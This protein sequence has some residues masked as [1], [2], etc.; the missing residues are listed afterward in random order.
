[1]KKTI[2]LLLSIILVVALSLPAM[3]SNLEAQSI[4]SHLHHLNQSIKSN[5]INDISTIEH[6]LQSVER[7][8][9]GVNGSSLV[10][11]GVDA[12]RDTLNGLNGGNSGGNSGGSGYTVKLMGNGEAVN[13]LKSFSDVSKDGEYYWA[14]DAIYAMK[15]EGL[16][17]GTADPDD[18]GAAPFSPKQTMTRAQFITV[19]VRHLFKGE[20]GTATTNDWWSANMDLA[21]TK[22]LVNKSDFNGDYDHPCSREEMAYLLISAA[23]IK[24]ESYNQASASKIPDYNNISGK[25]QTVALQAVA[26][27]L[28]NGKEGN[29]FDPQGTMSRAEAATVIYRLINPNAR[30]DTSWAM[31]DGTGNGVGQAGQVNEWGNVILDT[32]ASPVG[33]LTTDN[34][35]LSI[36]EGQTLGMFNWSI[37]QDFSRNNVKF[38]EGEKHPVPIQGDIVVKADG[39]E[40]K[41]DFFYGNDGKLICL[42]A[43]GCDIWTGA[44][45]LSGGE[46]FTIGVNAFTG[47][48]KGDGTNFKKGFNGEF[49]TGNM[50]MVL[51]QKAPRPS[52]QGAYDGE[53][54]DLFIWSAD[55]VTG[56]MVWN[57][58]GG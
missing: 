25:Y 54:V 21:E 6:L 19:L 53:V 4:A 46:Y 35:G 31:E 13:V 52:R 42:R 11:I 23:N 7:S 51:Q 44:T 34:H 40:V 2:S 36:D 28:I 8:V 30:V 9:N 18:N 29:K 48:F 26:G 17:N 56:Q 27:G 14:Y 3:A 10:L 15:D 43:P 38:N 32:K 45:F 58:Y 22:G 5:V 37:R 41:I 12:V 20:Q 50:W 1:M 33:N 49:F 39:T 24:G 16:F 57:W 55:L 47:N